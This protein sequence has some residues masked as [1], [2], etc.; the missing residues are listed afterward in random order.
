MLS[1]L[2]WLQQNIKMKKTNFEVEYMQSRVCVMGAVSVNHFRNFG[3][4]EISF[5]HL[6]LL[7][8]FPRKACQ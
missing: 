5:Q 1:L 8:G 7:S 6:I 3:A 4:E 2:C